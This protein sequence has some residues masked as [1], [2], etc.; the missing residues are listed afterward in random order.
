MLNYIFNY[1]Y[2]KK[3]I[4]NKIE[5]EYNSIY[6]FNISNKSLN[7]EYNK[8]RENIIGAIINNK[9]PKIFYEINKKWNIL[10]KNIKKYLNELIEIKEYDYLKLEHYGGRKYHYDFKIIVYIKNKMIKE[11]LIEFKYNIKN[12]NKSVEFISP[13]KPSLFLSSSYEE[14]YYDNY[15]IEISKISKLELPDKKQYLKEI[16]NNNPKCIIEY[17]KIYKKG[18]EKNKKKIIDNDV[19]FYNLCNKLA[20]ESIMEFIKI[21]NLDINKLSKYLNETQKNKIYMMYYDEKIYLENINNNY[22]IIEI[23]K[24]PELNRY[25]CI[26]E[27]GKKIKILLRWKNCNGIAFPAFQIS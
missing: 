9:I 17:K 15:L 19:I 25:E 16:N 26:L 13:S 24:N 5:L 4:Y 18:L 22:N 12:I 27:N 1:I 8:I 2:N 3:I 10:L 7:D 11:Y 21:N 23:K 6:K 20:H 14:Y